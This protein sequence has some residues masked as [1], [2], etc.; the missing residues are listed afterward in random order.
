MSRAIGETAPLIVIGAAG[1]VSNLP[2]APIS[3][4]FPFLNFAWLNSDFSVLPVQM[5]TWTADPD[6]AFQANAAAAG[7]VL[8]A[9]TL[10]MNAIAIT[11]R[12]RI[13]QRIKW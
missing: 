2:P 10:A 11:L 12:Y 7:L 4:R 6:P 9:F 1:W 8:I 3:N 13:R 5:F